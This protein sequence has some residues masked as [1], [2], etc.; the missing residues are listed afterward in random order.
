MVI[1]LHWFSLRRLLLA[2]VLVAALA[3]FASLR[4]DE[5]VTS[6]PEAEAV[7]AEAPEV[8]LLRFDRDLART[9]G[10]NS[11]AIID[12]EGRRLDDG[13]AGL[14]T[15]SSRVLLVH[16]AEEAEGTVTVAYVVRFA[17]AD[18]PSQGTVAFTVKP[19][20]APEA[21]PLASAVASEPRSEESIV[22]WTL[23]VMAGSAVFVM[24]LYFLR[25]A[26]GNARSSVDLDGPEA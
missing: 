19:G 4:A 16:F 11:A 22:L 20:A 13:R 17:G 25:V 18:A 9:A 5:L 15:Y 10:A 14:A 2:A 7:L 24:G 1:L 3:P 26:T 21:D 23:A 6:E 8:I 12:A